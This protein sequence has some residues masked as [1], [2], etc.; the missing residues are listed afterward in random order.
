M[1]NSSIDWQDVHPTNRYAAEIVMGMRPSCEMERLAC[2]RHLD[3]LK[4]Q[5]TEGFPYV[6]DESRADRIFEWFERCCRHVRGPFSGELIE[7]VPFQK[8][9]LG[10]VFGWVHLDSGKRRFRKA[11]H[12]RARGNV[13]STEMSGLA[14]YGM[15]GDCVYPPG[16]PDLKRYEDSPEVECAAVDKGQA[17][18][19]W[20]D[21]MKMGENSPDISKRLRIKRTYIEHAK[22]GGWL[23]PLSKDTKNKDSGAPCL[24]IIDEYHAHQTSEIVD[25]SYSGFGKRLQSLMQI[26]STAGKDSENSPCKKEYDSLCKMM[27]GE[28]D[29]Q[30]S[31][32]VMIREIEQE[33][34]PHDETIW[35]KGSPILQDE[36]EYSEELRKQMRAEHDDAYNSGDPSKIREFLTKRMNRWQ[37]DSENKYMS[38]IMDKWKALAISR[39]AF[40]DLVR[41]YVTWNGLDLSKTT[42]LTGSGFVFRL[43]D[44]RYAVTAHGF[45]P[46]ETATK[47]EHSDRVPYRQWADDGWCTI[48][49]GAVVDYN[50]IKSNI[51]QMET[52]ESWFIQEICY[53]PYNATHF[54]QQL[55]AEGYE[56]VEIRQGVQTLSE[57]TKFFRELVL[58][59]LIVHDGSPLLTWCLSNAVEVKDNNDNIKLSKKNKDDSQRIDLIAAI[60]NAMVRAMVGDSRINLNEHIMSDDFSF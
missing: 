56:R 54:T 45:M 29:M 22:R 4:R 25:V 48:T 36:N 55:E 35:V 14:L 40:L 8:F 17:K 58:K 15:C 11:F 7:L 60:M 1:K 33:D 21:A 59:G 34:D 20:L 10:A 24:V 44:G 30:D 2:Q 51:Q 46:E 19:V 37:A 9:D 38:G 26:I 5:A 43:P 57:P 53:D 41:G 12:M 49:P 50:Y 42:D 31:Y 23:R 52:D 13:K 28:T 32:F 6:F 3:D 16:R 39:D 27:K 18:R 47:H